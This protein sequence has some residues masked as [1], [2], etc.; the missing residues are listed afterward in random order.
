VKIHKIVKLVG[1]IALLFS[2]SPLNREQE[3][4]DMKHILS[5]DASTSYEIVWEKSDI[6]LFDNQSNPIMVT[7]PNELI[8]EGKQSGDS[9]IYIFAFNIQDGAPL[10]QSEVDSSPAQLL[11]SN[12]VLYRGT[13]GTGH[14][15]AYDIENGKLLWD[16]ALPRARSIVDLY[17]IDGKL[18]ANT[19]NGI[20]FVLSQE[21]VILESIRTTNGIFYG[22]AA[23]IYLEESNAIVSK[24]KFTGVVRWKLD[25]EGTFRHSPIFDKN[26]IYLRTSGV[27]NN[28]TY[29]I[30]Q[31]SG[32]VNWQLSTNAIS[33]LYKSDSV[34]YYLTVD[35]YLVSLD[36]QSGQEIE[37]IEFSPPFELDGYGYI[38]RYY[39]TADPIN[40]IVVVSFGDSDQILGIKTKP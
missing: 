35:G 17:N 33:N 39:V 18:F 11:V 15:Q 12:K 9:R 2:C 13:G 1:F 14:I 10:W 40:D 28:I 6:K 3:N 5:S 20:S 37:R 38:G 23:T 30:D 4:P 29:S 31:S 21:G 16:T 7:T 8:L 34:V 24:D 27:P 22:T 25:L 36:S 32:I 19:N 26:T